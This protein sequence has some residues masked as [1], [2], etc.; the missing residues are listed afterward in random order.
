MATENTP[1]LVSIML[2]NSGIAQE[3]NSN[4]LFRVILDKDNDF[5]PQKRPRHKK[6]SDIE[7]I[8]DYFI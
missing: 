8:Q 2:D 1:S 7:N 3:D 4:A 6:F 5:P